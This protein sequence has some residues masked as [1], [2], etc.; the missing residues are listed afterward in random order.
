MN[1]VSV[2]ARP[3]TLIPILLAG[4]ACLLITIYPASPAQAQQRVVIRGGDEPTL[5]AAAKAGIIDVL[6][7]ALNEEYVFPEKAKE[8]ETARTDGL[9]EPDELED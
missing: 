6:T 3:K 2:G 4:L 5:D 8:M 7:E 9:V 1:V